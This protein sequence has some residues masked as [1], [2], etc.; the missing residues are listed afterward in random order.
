METIIDAADKSNCQVLDNTNAVDIRLMQ[1]C[2]HVPRHYF[3]PF[4]KDL[5]MLF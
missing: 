2:F 3:C 1:F 5:N 4:V